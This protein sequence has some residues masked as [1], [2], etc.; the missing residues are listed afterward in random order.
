MP[1]V[2]KYSPKEELLRR[3]KEFAHSPA[4]VGSSAMTFFPYNNSTR[5]NMFTS[6]LNQFINTIN[7]NFPYVFT[8][9]ENTV[10]K[11][12][13]GYTK[14][15]GRIE[16]FR[17]VCKYEELTDT[18]YVYQLF[19]WDCE[20]ERYD[21]F[22]R[23]EV[24]DLGQDFGYKFD[25]TKLD[26]LSEGDVVDEGE[27]LVK[28][29]SYDD[30]MNY[31]YGKN[32]LVAYT[33]DPFEFEDAAT[34]SDDF[35]EGCRNVASVRKKW[36]WNNN[37][38]PLNVH[39]D[40]NTDEYR[41][42]PWIGE[43]ISGIITSARP[44]INEQLL[45]DFKHENLRKI[46]DSDKTIYYNGTGTVIDYD[47]LCNN[48]DLPHNSFNAQILQILDSQNRYWK[49][50]QDACVEII[51][52]GKKYSRKIDQL[53]DDSRKY[54]ERNPKRKWNNGSSVFGNLEIRIHIVEYPK[55]SDG[56]KFTARFGNKSVVARVLPKH[57]MP[58]TA[59]GRHVQVLL[60]M[61]AVPNRTTGFVMHELD[62]TWLMG[63]A[64]RHM[65][66]LPTLKEKA[67]VLFDLLDRLNPAHG[68]RERTLYRG[69]DKKEKE[70]YIQSAITTGIFSHQDMIN[71]NES[72]FFKLKRAHEELPYAKEDTLYVYRFGH[73]YRMYQTYCL[74]S[75]YMFP[76][77]QTDKRGF[78]VRATGAINLK[79][80]PERSYKNKRGEA[81]FSDTAI[82]FGEY[83]ALTMMI[84][85]DPEDLVAM[86]A[87]Y[88]TSPEASEDFTKAQFNKSCQAA[89]KKY[90]KSRPAEIINIY[91]RHLGVDPVFI[92]PDQDINPISSRN[93]REHVGEDGRT[94]ICSDLDFH[95]IQI[96]NRIRKEVMMEYAILTTEELEKKVEE[97]FRE[98]HILTKGYDGRGF[99]PELLKT[100]EENVRKREEDERV[101]AEAIQKA[102]EAEESKEDSEGVTSEE[103]LIEE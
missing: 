74:G 60:A 7:P 29:M 8:G 1:E 58:F 3:N 47:I 5:T 51:H 63:C 57:L 42:L 53:Y 30:Y 103:T 83:E 84:A 80:L 99:S 64:R 78:S 65:D 41:P 49:R 2:Q 48:P 26:S 81:P 14:T 22:T 52:S 82:R 79:G 45:Y 11:H 61:P 38:K 50:V 33:F 68:E 39:G 100:L 54:L 4:I 88:R 72:I 96:K 71:E 76:L 20:K 91:F 93:F 24:K 102:M 35:A 43:E 56:G 90:Y 66:T 21:V 23:T 15:K 59:D 27:V 101:K 95:K 92:D 16:V 9:A 46:R 85:M 34:I 87:A 86:E 62:I 55:L 25:N 77:K 97:R 37:D 13:T 18:P 6:H 40:P 75:M 73:V 31:R 10:G 70:E 98:S 28:S 19:Y 32:A 36:G 94:Y 67:E 89:F 12:S 69:L 17:K 44:Q